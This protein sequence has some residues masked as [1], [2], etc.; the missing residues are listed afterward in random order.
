MQVEVVKLAAAAKTGSMD[1]LKAAYGTARDAC[2][3]CH[4]TYTS[5]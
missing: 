4:D 3:T 2:K 1:N 5:Q